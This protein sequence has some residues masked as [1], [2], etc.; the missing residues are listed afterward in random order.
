MSNEIGFDIDLRITVDPLF[1]SYRTR[2][3][4]LSISI[5]N[6]DA[7]YSNSKHFILLIL[8]MSHSL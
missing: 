6:I 2:S 7:K 1:S 5:E 4:P 8:T 3:R